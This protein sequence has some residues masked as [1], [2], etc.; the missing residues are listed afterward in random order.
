MQ[1][2]HP[3]SSVNVLQFNAA[4][5]PYHN[6]RLGKP[7]PAILATTADTDDR[8][9]SGHSFKHVNTLQAA[10]I[11][12]SPLLVR[13]QMRAG[14]GAGKT[15]DKMIEETADRWAFAAHW[16]GLNVKPVN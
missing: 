3:L 11:C 8:V 4:Y 13:F 5:S 7:Y 12:P 2:T 14:H 6:I 9:A 10:D 15:T 16:T 1:L